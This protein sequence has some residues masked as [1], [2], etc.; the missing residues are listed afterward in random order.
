MSWIPAKSLSTL[1]L[2]TYLLTYVATN[3][4][5]FIHNWRSINGVNVHACDFWSVIVCRFCIFSRR[6]C[7]H[8]DE[9]LKKTL[10]T[11]LLY[12]SLH[13]FLWYCNF[14]HKARLKS[15]LQQRRLHALVTVKCAVNVLRNHCFSAY[16]F[17]TI[18]ILKCILICLCVF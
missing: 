13:E 12:P 17:C 14:L 18:S 15:W 16:P 7:M 8:F 2:L 11:V 4:C 5:E 3:S 9:Y 10:I 6:C 1:D